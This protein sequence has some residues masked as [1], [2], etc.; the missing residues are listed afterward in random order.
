MMTSEKIKEVIALEKVDKDISSEKGYSLWTAAVFMISFNAGL[1]LLALPHA[2]A[3]TG[4]FG[5]VLI[6]L[7]SLNSCYSSIILGETW[8]I[9]ERQWE[10]YRGKFRYPYPAIGMRAA[11]AWMRYVV[12]GTLH[13]TAVGV[14]VVYL[15][16]S[17][18]VGQSMCEEY[19]SLGYKT[20]IIIL[21]TIL[22]PLTWFGSIEKFKFAGLG[23]MLSILAACLAMIVGIVLDLL[24]TET[25]N[26]EPPTISSISMSFGT[27]LFAFGGIFFYV[28][29]QNDM[30]CKQQFNK[31]SIVSFITL[32]ILYI[33]VTVTGYMVY[34]SDVAPNLIF[35][36]S[37]G[38]LRTF[39]EVCLAIH[40]FLAILLG[41]NPVV[42]EIE[43]ALNVPSVFNYKRCLIRT[44]IIFLVVTIGY[45]IP[46][47]DKMMNL[48]GGSTTTL[49]TFIFP[50]LFYYLIKKN[51][52]FIEKIFLLQI[53]L[54]GM[55]G[56]ISCTFFAVLD[57]IQTF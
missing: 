53:V 15:L 13:T 18:Q 16:V 10:E 43:E 46:H 55:A 34:G 4:W 50:S 56:G 14:S 32:L 21:G 29:V 47:F 37:K 17:A 25:V 31:A 8:L 48:V 20:W 30:R 24:K 33:P 19:F 7:A 36:L 57:I 1:G 52:S 12:T 3:G 11:G 39:I 35:S 51:V 45:T 41:I 9:M 6:A 40:T 44:F 26:W 54:V 23:A 28:T 27:M 2:L 5:I 38:S 49:L 42:Q 22:C